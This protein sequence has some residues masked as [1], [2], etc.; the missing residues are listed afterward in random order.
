MNFLLPSSIVPMSYLLRVTKFPVSSYHTFFFLISLP[1]LSYLLHLFQYLAKPSSSGRPLCLFPFNLNSNVLFGILLPTIL[2]TQTN[3]CN[4]LTSSSVNKS[5]I[6]V[7]V[8]LF[9]NS[10]HPC[11][12]HDT[13]HTCN[14]HCQDLALILK[15]PHF[16]VI[17]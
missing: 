10:V 8:S 3:H 11:F 15:G 4:C 6:P 5:G 13:S 17:C 2:L 9:P 1:A 7:S 12:S 14:A 16:Y